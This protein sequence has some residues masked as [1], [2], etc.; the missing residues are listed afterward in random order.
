MLVYGLGCDM[1]ENVSAST[2]PL[3]LIRPAGL[4]AATPSAPWI[5]SPVWLVSQFVK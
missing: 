4:T 3:Q 5:V 2:L 1:V